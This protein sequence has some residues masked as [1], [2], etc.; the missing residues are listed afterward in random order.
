MYVEL[1]LTNMSNV[2]LLNVCLF[3]IMDRGHVPSYT[4]WTIVHFFYSMLSCTCSIFFQ[5]IRD[6]SGSC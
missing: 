2:L 4:G 3:S 1:E 6:G 5:T